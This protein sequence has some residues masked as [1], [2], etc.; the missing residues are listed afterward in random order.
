MHG[1]VCG[2]AEEKIWVCKGNNPRCWA[3]GESGGQMVRVRTPGGE[4]AEAGGCMQA[5]LGG[6]MEVRVKVSA[7]V[8][9]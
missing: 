3:T 7:R 4:V 1:C 2:E 9:V 5:G 6:G 8:R